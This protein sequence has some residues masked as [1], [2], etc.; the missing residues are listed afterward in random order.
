[1]DAINEQAPVA[2]AGAEAGAE[3]ARAG[4]AA[5]AMKSVRPSVDYR[6]V[7]TIFP[8]FETRVKQQD[9]DEPMAMGLLVDFAMFGEDDVDLKQG[10]LLRALS[11]LK[12]LERPCMVLDLAPVRDL[13]L[14]LSD[15]DYEESEAEKA[16]LR[17][18]CARIVLPAAQIADVRL[19]QPT[20]GSSIV[21]CNA[22]VPVFRWFQAMNLL[23]HEKKT[24]TRAIPFP[25]EQKDGSVT[26]QVM[27][28]TP[29][30]FRQ[31]QEL[32][33]HC[34]DQDGPAQGFAIAAKFAYEL[35]VRRGHTEIT[36][37]QVGHLVTDIVIMGKSH[38]RGVL[39]TNSTAEDFEGAE[40]L[41]LYF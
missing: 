33:R 21:R 19:L 24:P 12:L 2:E 1:M 17:P 9:T 8:R 41:S 35:L 20:V 26:Y 15:K 39:V 31:Y 30:E 28:V 14:V 10:A 36:F 4:P 11:D 6:R 32:L 40:K 3:G 5:K 7:E 27:R 13:E 34:V 38:M 18:P 29:E 16:E 37:A 22:S 25:M 23:L